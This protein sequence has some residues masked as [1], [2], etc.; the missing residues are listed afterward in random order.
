[1]R[2]LFIIPFILVIFLG[3]FSPVLDV[4]AEGAIQG[5]T[6]TGSALPQANLSD[7]TL[8][9]ASQGSQAVSQQE[10]AISGWNPVSVISSLIS[11]FFGTIADVVIRIAGFFVW[12]PAVLLNLVIDISVINMGSI[13]NN[14]DAIEG[15]WS[16]L[17]DISNLIFIFV[18]LYVSIATV[19]R[20]SSFGTMRLIRNVILVAL[21]I[22][23]SLFFTKVIIDTSNLLAL[24]MYNRTGIADTGAGNKFSEA[25]LTAT[26][27]S[28]I[29]SL[30][31]S[32]LQGSGALFN[33]SI[34]YKA[35]GVLSDTTRLLLITV[36][37]S[38]FL[39]VLSFVLF[40]ATI[41]FANRFVTLIL[42]MVF[43]PLAYLAMI[44]PQTQGY[45]RTWW[46]ALFAQAFF[47]PLFFALMFVVLKIVQSESFAQMAVVSGGSFSDVFISGSVASVGI[48]LNFV[49]VIILLN[50]SLIIAQS[51]GIKGSS[52]IITLGK[53]IKG[54]LLANTVGR[55][56]LGSIAATG[57]I[58]R[59]IQRRLESNAV[60]R[61]ITGSLKTLNRLT[62]DVPSG[63]VGVVRQGIKRGV[64]SVADSKFG[65]TVSYKDIN[66]EIYTYNT[67][68]NVATKKQEINS[69][70]WR[71][72]KEKDPT[73]KEALKSELQ[74]I[75]NSISDKQI[76]EIG[77]SNLVKMAD[78]LKDKQIDAIKKSDEF[79]EADKEEISKARIK[80]LVDVLDNGGSVAEIKA[81]LAKFSSKAK[82]EFIP[83]LMQQ[84]PDAYIVGP[85][86]V[87]GGEFES[88]M[89]SKDLTGEQK[90]QLS[91]NRFKGITEAL[92]G[93][94]GKGS[95]NSKRVEELME[96]LTPKDVANLPD[97]L[98]SNAELLKHITTR[99]IKAMI[100]EGIEPSVS[101]EI[102][103]NLKAP[104]LTSTQEDRHNEII[105][106]ITNGLGKGM[107][108]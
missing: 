63:V 57:S 68:V 97:I 24:E 48:V 31:T 15:S 50:A 41:L 80:G 19:L 11:L 53:N 40:A 79:S 103:R 61:G 32:N 86:T 8:T 73:K 81:E 42:L 69:F 22:N 17:R 18:L 99:H 85:E 98:K 84:Y 56:A 10:G 34:A 105:E 12:L 107:F 72:D 13:V 74:G 7:G 89:K 95:V 21:F 33:D 29:Y 71:I 39:L 59:G 55:T 51:L 47:A 60:G 37:G 45:A 92:G 96:K 70:A 82:D 23:F 93:L 64:Q 100:E 6:F 77:K 25:I 9:P 46:H 3:C 16:A 4:H 43:S 36:G 90:K 94:D 27:L 49:V 2:K 102:R 26:R 101:A 88:M 44:L 83:D 14:M 67:E 65:G 76:L 38:V 106:Y 104:D 30:D 54:R 28:T 91:E 108:A 52:S 66:K 20:L 78:M 62:G 75:L 87:S 35:E 58:T 5:N 1:M